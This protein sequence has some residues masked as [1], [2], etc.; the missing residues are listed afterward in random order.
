MIQSR[1]RVLDRVAVEDQIRAE[2]GQKSIILTNGGGAAGPTMTAIWLK[3]PANNARM[4]KAIFASHH[5]NVSAVYYMNRSNGTN[6]YVLAGCESGSRD[7]IET[8]NYLVSTAAGP[9]GPDIAILLRENAR[10]SGLPEM[11][12][13]HGG[14]DWGSQ[15]ITLLLSGPGVKIGT[16]NAPARLVDI[17]PTIERF[18]GMTPEARD[19]LVLADAF[20]QPM[21][22]DMATQNASSA[23]LNLHVNALMARA[24][25]DVSLAQRGLLP[26]VIPADE[27]PVIH[28]KRR[29][30]ITAACITTLGATG[31]ALAKI[32]PNVRKDGSTLNWEE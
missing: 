22:P 32:I 13:R 5:D 2:L 20:Q 11:L 23:Q 27:Q 12:G 17:A 18:M 19:G 10:N 29:L 26:N 8:Y 16:S 1:H 31:G 28:W 4:A 6:S 3:N 24:Q 21:A 14:A 15:H 30:A 7:L 9:T 25:S